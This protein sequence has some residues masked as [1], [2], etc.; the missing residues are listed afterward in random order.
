MINYLP[1]REAQ[2][3]SEVARAR[4]AASLRHQDWFDDVMLSQSPIAIEYNEKW[5]NEDGRIAALA[6][7]DDD[8][9]TEFGL[10]RIA[11]SHVPH[12]GDG[13]D[14]TCILFIG[15]D[16]GVISVTSRNSDVAIAGAPYHI[17]SCDLWKNASCFEEKLE[18]ALYRTEEL[19]RSAQA[20]LARGGFLLRHRVKGTP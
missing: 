1:T 14:E 13:L 10:G 6:A 5:T 17:D 8:L 16:F 9:H 20:F 3:I 12:S 7:L 18:L 4:S 15:T 11:F 19:N 2:A